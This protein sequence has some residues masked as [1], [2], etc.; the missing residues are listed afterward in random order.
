MPHSSGGG[1]HGGGFHGGSGGGRSGGI[2][3]SGPRV[4][5]HYFAGAHRYVYYRRNRPIY[6]Y[7]TSRVDS[8]SWKASVIAWAVFFLIFLSGGILAIGGEFSPPVKLELNYEDT[9]LLVADTADILSAEETDRLYS[10][11]AEFQDTTGITPALLTVHNEDWQGKYTSLEN[12]AY[13]AYVNRFKDER[14]WLMVYSEPEQPDPSFVEWYWEGMQGDDTD[15][16]ITEQVA[17]KMNSAV[18]KYLTMNSY[19]VG[20]AFAQGFS[21]ILPGI[22]EGS[23]DP[24]TVAAFFMVII[25]PCGFAVFRIVSAILSRGRAEAVRCQTDQGKVLEDKCGYCGGVYVHGLH[26]SCPH[27]GAPI[28]VMQGNAE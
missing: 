22:M 6:Y 15:R 13:D 4:S 5:S 19:T 27:C 23:V 12:Y 14:H 24:S 7:S 3:S 28:T 2:G 17:D 18:H 10:V 26:E 20:D 16:I 11:F 9:E 25:L 21:D 1:S 8:S